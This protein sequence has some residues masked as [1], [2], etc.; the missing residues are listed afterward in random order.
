[1]GVPQDASVVADVT[2]FCDDT[3]RV[4]TEDEYTINASTLVDLADVVVGTGRG[5]MEAASMAKVLM[6]PV[7]GNAYPVLVTPDVFERLYD[8]NFSVRAV[9]GDHDEEQTIAR[10]ACL[11]SDDEMRREMGKRSRA[12]YDE[13]FAIESVLDKYCLIYKTLT[14]SSR[15]CPFDFM[16]HM[17]VCVRGFLRLRLRERTSL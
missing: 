7:A 4:V 15:A 10:M 1:L 12:W 13:H 14:S 17:V 9:L 11:L 6:V 3:I 2:P 16:S 8:Y 5:L